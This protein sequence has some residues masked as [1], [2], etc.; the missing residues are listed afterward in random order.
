MHKGEVKPFSALILI[1]LFMTPGTSLG[2]EVEISSIDGVKAELKSCLIRMIK[3]SPKTGRPIST[4]IA[5]RCP[6]IRVEQDSARSAGW[7]ARIASYRGGQR[8]LWDLALWGKRGELLLESTQLPA[9]QSPLDALALA[10]GISHELSPI[11]EVAP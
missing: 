4:R 11:F 2:Q 6:A 9:G 8:G 7:E 10:L 3:K 1:L 5:S